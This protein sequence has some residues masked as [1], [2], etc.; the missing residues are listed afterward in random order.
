MENK[1]V[2]VTLFVHGVLANGYLW[3]HQRLRRRLSLHRH[4]QL[5]NL[6]QTPA[7]PEP[8]APY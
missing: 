3:R 4:P 2:P 6:L 7:Q 8:V 5:H 1:E